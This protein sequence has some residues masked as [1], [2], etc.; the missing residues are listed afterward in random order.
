VVARRLAEKKHPFTAGRDHISHTLI[1]TG[2]GT[3]STVLLIAAY[4]LLGVAA[5][6]YL[7][8]FL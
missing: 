6:A 2:L 8:E 7:S 5:A 4:H 3:R 1:S